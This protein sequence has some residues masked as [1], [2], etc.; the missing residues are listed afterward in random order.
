MLRREK[1]AIGSLY[2]LAHASA[3]DDETCIMMQPDVWTKVVVGMLPAGD[4]PR[5][6]LDS[7]PGGMG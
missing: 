2:I 7:R 1:S 3:S 4:G 5:E 6:M